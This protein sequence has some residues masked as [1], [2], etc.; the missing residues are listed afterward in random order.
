[1]LKPA[2]ESRTAVWNWL[3]AAGIPGGNITD[4]G[5]WLQVTTP[6]QTVESALNNTFFWYREL[7]SGQ[8]RIRALQYSVPED[9]RA[10][11]NV[12]QPTTRFGQMSPQRLDSVF[13][14]PKAALQ[15][16]SLHTQTPGMNRTFCNGT[17]TPKCLKQMY[18]IHYRAPANTANKIGFASF[19]NESARY[20][21]LALFE[22]K[23]APTALG[24]TL[25]VVSTNGAL[26]DQSPGGSTEANLDSQYLVGVASGVPVTEYI[27][28][29]LS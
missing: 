9:V 21:D 5:D 6:V 8:R 11:I 1:M 16:I 15:D 20:S 13:C 7:S 25:S 29:G 27:T 24:Q 26:D 22:E 28:S 4:K 3:T 12:I 10:H 17:T 19:L 23:L 14:L 2:D 18:N